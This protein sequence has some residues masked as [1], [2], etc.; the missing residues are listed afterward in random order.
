MPI[1][2]AATNSAENSFLVCHW[3][4]WLDWLDKFCLVLC[5]GTS[6][7]LRGTGHAVNTNSVQ[8]MINAIFIANKNL[9]I[10]IENIILWK[11]RNAAHTTYIPSH[12]WRIGLD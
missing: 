1:S 6:R 7:F 12:D 8:Y 2:L 3:R 9:S 10:N 4:V 5:H 11:I